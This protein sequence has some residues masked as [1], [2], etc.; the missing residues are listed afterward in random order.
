MK[1]QNLILIITCV[2]LILANAILFFGDK[3]GYG[4]IDNKQFTLIDTVSLSNIRFVQGDKTVS[5]DRGES[6]L[7][8]GKG[9][10]A[11]LL[12]ILMAVLT[13]VEVNRQVGG[14]LGAAILENAQSRGV[15][16][17]LDEDYQYTVIGNENLTK[18]YFI[19]DD[20]EVFE[21][22]I[23][24]YNDFIG[25][26]YSLSPLQWQDRTIFN[27]S[28]RT[29]QSLELNYLDKEA[30]KIQFSGDFFDIEGVNRID[31]LALEDY[32]NQF[33]RLQV[34]ERLNREEYPQYDSLL[35]SA[36]LAQMVV[37]NLRGEKLGLSIFPAFGSDNFHLLLTDGGELLAFDRRRMSGLLREP[38]YFRYQD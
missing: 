15:S 27:G 6:W 26:I 13:K 21:V 18:T 22:G 5:L 32:L 23:P 2:A 28:V 19:N 29:I 31:T 38:Q 30:L 16:V 37:L 1:R 24:G 25:S 17:F 33:I 7:I 9:V 20:Q 34:N 14:E 8:E 4:T 10:D 11:S 3:S 35:N 36:P 12:K